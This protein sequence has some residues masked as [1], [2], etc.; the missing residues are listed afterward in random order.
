A[1]LGWCFGCEN[2]VPIEHIPT[3][4]QLES[5]LQFEIDNPRVVESDLQMG[6]TE[7][8]HLAW[9][10]SRLNWRKTRTSPQHCLICGGTDILDLGERLAAK[11]GDIIAS[12]PSCMADGNL[13]H[14]GGGLVNYL[15]I[16]RYS[17]DGQ[18][19]EADSDDG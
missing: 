10:N 1:S 13:V 4:Q 17:P 9:A 18:R 15:A 6:L 7:N 14:Q 12:H 19:L 8:N 3:L 16:E 11:R 5:E 2:A